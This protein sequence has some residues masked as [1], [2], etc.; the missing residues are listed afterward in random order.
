MYLLAPPDRHALRSAESSPMAVAGVA[1]VLLATLATKPVWE[2]LDHHDPSVLTKPA[3]VR[4]CADLF[5]LNDANLTV[6]D[7]SADT[8]FYEKPRFVQH[9]DDAAVAAIKAYYR[10]VLPRRGRILDLMSSWTSHLDDGVGADKDDGHFEHVA[11]LGL[12]LEELQS[13]RALHEYHVADINEDPYLEHFAPTSFDAVICSLSIG[14]VRHPMRMLVEIRRVLK[15]GGVAVFT[16][17]DRFFPT[18]AISAWRRATETGRLWL[19]G[20][21]FYYVGG[22]R[23]PVAE[24]LTRGDR[25]GASPVFAVSATK[26]MPFGPVPQPWDW[27][28]E[29]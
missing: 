18:K 7:P 13:N 21:Y 6:E 14:Y 11:G 15:Q 1:A 24:I 16:W 12:N 20:C 27:K 23:L 3:F 19:A 22:Y 29:L 17:S 28:S 9:V 26:A 8:V 10:R 25:H 2:S 4:E 5:P